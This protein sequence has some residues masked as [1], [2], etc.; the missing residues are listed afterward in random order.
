MGKSREELLAMA[1]EHEAKKGLYRYELNHMLVYF[2]LD[3]TSMF[4]SMNLYN[5]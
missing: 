2:M 1:K 4:R 5:M 3:S